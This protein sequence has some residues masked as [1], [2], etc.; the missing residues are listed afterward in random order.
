MKQRSGGNNW[1]SKRPIRKSF[2]R[3][4]FVCACERAGEAK[5]CGC[6]KEGCLSTLGL[7]MVRFSPPAAVGPFACLL[8]F[9]C[10]LFDVIKWLLFVSFFARLCF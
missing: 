4:V 3:C 1:Y 10:F 2:F 9:V 6:L 8:L 7:R 5:L